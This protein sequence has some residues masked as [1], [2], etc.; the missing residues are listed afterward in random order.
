MIYDKKTKLEIP[1]WFNLKNYDELTNLTWQNL[2]DE[3]IFRVNFYAN[4]KIKGA[5][6]EYGN[7]IYIFPNNASWQRIISGNPLISVDNSNVKDCRC[8]S[9]YKGVH[10]ITNHELEHYDSVIKSRNRTNYTLHHNSPAD[11]E[12]INQLCGDCQSVFTQSVDNVYS[13]NMCN[14]LKIFE[15]RHGLN[16]GK[17]NTDLMFDFYIQNNF[18]TEHD[19][20]ICFEN[21]F[22]SYWL[23]DSCEIIARE[24]GYLIEF[25]SL[26][27]SCNVCDEY[28]VNLN[29]SDITSGDLLLRLD[30]A[31]NT[32]EE[33][34]NSFTGIVKEARKQFQIPN[35]F[36]NKYNKELCFLQG[37]I[38]YQLI[39][40]MDLCLW[41]VYKY[42]LSK[43]LLL[44]SK[45]ECLLFKL[46]CEI[47]DKKILQYPIKIISNALYGSSRSDTYI[48][49]TNFNKKVI[50]R[51]SDM[52]NLESAQSFLNKE[53]IG[54][55]KFSL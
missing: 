36:K 46:D 30:L 50:P 31:N 43:P 2:L 6:D 39:P 9:G 48:G 44:N 45:S 38:K 35:V 26:P 20:Y 24:K 17:E 12:F 11:E 54:R 13:D 23:C 1:E 19:N 40:Y 29:Q 51:Y 3:L 37:I 28:S 49:G 34:I 41:R 33:L 4:F 25:S 15:A 5:Q 42:V 18:A 53:G 52:K 14:K 55:E 22:K 27:S 7:N 10:T 47:D 8:I 16:R 32:N 21:F